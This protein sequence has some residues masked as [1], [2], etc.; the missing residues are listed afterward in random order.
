MA[1][2]QAPAGSRVSRRDFL[3]AA[4][5]GGA[6]AIAIGLAGSS[7]RAA[8]MSPRAMSYRNSPNGNQSCANCANFEPPS[9]CKVVDGTISPGGWC[10]LYRAK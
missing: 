2:E 10:I 5:L 6:G 7:A 9:S 3:F 8:K 1:Q 4:G